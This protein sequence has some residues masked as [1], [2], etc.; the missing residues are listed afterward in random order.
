[1]I[2]KVCERP[3]EPLYQW[4]NGF[5]ISGDCK[6]L[7]VVSLLIGPRLR[8]LMVNH[9]QP[10]GLPS[11]RLAKPRAWPIFQPINTAC[12]TVPIT[13]ITKLIE[14]C[15][16][17]PILTALPWLNDAQWLDSGVWGI[18]FVFTHKAY[19]QLSR[20]IYA[21]PRPDGLATTSGNG[22]HYQLYLQAQPPQCLSCSQSEK[23]LPFPWMS[24]CRSLLAQRE[25]HIY[26]FF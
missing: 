12:F 2:R 23:S 15:K 3:L 7:S 20:L 13:C 14:A 4:G 24:D 6:H 16:N 10:Q 18:A 19:G 17:L 9:D 8:H 26:L 1:M 21:G 11:E 5:H 22:S 25:S